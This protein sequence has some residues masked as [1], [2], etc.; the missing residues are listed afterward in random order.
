MKH[1]AQVFQPTE[2]QMMLASFANMETV[3]IAAYSHLLDTI[4]MPEAEYSAFLEY[5]EMKD[6][7]DY[8]QQWGVGTKADIA[9]TLAVSG[10]FTEGLPLRSEARRVG[11][12]CVSTCRSRSSPSHYKKKNK[13]Y[14]P[15]RSNTQQ[16]YQK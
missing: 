8:M 6:K 15:P 9:K 4:G 5:K 11:K 1:Y 16:H 3:H 2:V 12:D 13:L 14:T 7:Y 10:G